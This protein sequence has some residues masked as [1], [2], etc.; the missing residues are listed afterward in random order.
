MREQAVHKL[1]V[2]SFPLNKCACILAVVQNQFCGLA[3]QD[4]SKVIRTP[5]VVDAWANLCWDLCIFSQVLTHWLM[6]W[7]I[8]TSPT[9]QGSRTH[10]VHRFFAETVKVRVAKGVRWVSSLGEDE[11]LEFLYLG[12][13]WL[14]RSCWTNRIHISDPRLW[15]DGTTFWANGRRRETWLQLSHVPRRGCGLQS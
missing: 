3:L 1:P 12:K 2:A 11:T 14:Y 8:K 15:W 5:S 6:H 4:F 7:F 13:P 10:F 9:I